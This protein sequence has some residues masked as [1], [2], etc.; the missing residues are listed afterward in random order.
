MDLLILAM[1]FLLMLFPI[2]AKG[3]ANAPKPDSVSQL[4]NTDLH[5]AVGSLPLGLVVGRGHETTLQP[6]S[7]L[8]FCDN[9]TIVA[10]FVTQEE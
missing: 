4:W 8:W 1:A 9:D 6:K 5:A 10:T 2:S 7:S 3:D